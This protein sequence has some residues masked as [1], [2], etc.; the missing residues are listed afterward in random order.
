MARPAAVSGWRAAVRSDTRAPPEPP[1]MMAGVMSRWVSSPASASACM[2]DSDDPSKH[3]SDSPQLG[4]SQI[5]TLLPCSASA[6]A[7]CRTPGDSLVK[8]PPGVITQGWPD[9]PITSYA[10]DNPLISAMGTNG[11]LR[12]GGGVLR[13][14]LAEGLRG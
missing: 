10:S 11:L 13:G 9:S 2:A 5:S 4:R 8:R 3:T 14:Y 1:A 12:I 6:S 7:S